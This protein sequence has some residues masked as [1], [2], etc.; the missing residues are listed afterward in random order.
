MLSGS[1]VIRCFINFVPAPAHTPDKPDFGYTRTRNLNL[2]WHVRCLP[3]GSPPTPE[4]SSRQRAT[5]S[6]GPS[7]V[8][9][10]GA[11]YPQ[12][13]FKRSTPVLP[14][15]RVVSETGLSRRQSTATLTA[16]ASESTLVSALKKSLLQWAE[17]PPLT[18]RS[19]LTSSCHRTQ[20]RGQT[21]G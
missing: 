20:E 10:F 5:P 14:S 9:L 4:R 16:S 18:T 2:E 6:F 11:H 12:S 8:M 1:S 19:S 3:C 17:W 13:V 7:V 15:S 21:S